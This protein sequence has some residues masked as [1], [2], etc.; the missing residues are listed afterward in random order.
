MPILPPALAKAVRY[1]ISG[2]S[3]AVVNLG[4]FAVM[5]KVFGVWYLAASIAAFLLSFVVSFVLQRSWTFEVRGTTA[6]V[7][8]TSLYFIAALANLALNTF[9]VFLLVEYA[10]SGSLLAQ[11]IAGVIVACESFFVYRLIFKI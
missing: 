2:G 10:G 6:L 8:H 3:A 7:E 1:L 9:I 5:T 11:F 4:S